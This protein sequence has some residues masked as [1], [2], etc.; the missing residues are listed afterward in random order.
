MKGRQTHQLPLSLGGRYSSPTDSTFSPVTTAMITGEDYKMRPL[1]AM[2]ARNFSR[3]EKEEKDLTEKTNEGKVDHQRMHAKKQEDDDL[4][5]IIPLQGAKKYSRSGSG[6]SLPALGA[7]S[8]L[9]SPTDA[10]FSPISSNF[11]KKSKG[12][13]LQKMD[14]RKSIFLRQNKK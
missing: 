8:K 4:S 10:V 11:Y 14:A 2:A 6:S 1:Q 3:R 7:R 12:G 13:K 5:V 9:F